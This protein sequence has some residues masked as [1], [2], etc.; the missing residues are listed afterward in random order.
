MGL[1]VGSHSGFGSTN[2]SQVITLLSRAQCLVLTFALSSAWLPLEGDVSY[3][4]WE[5]Q[6][7]LSA[8]ERET[9]RLAGVTQLYWQVGT[10]A[11]DGK[12]WRW[13]E[14]INLDWPAMTA[15]QNHLSIV[16]VLRLA[17]DPGEELP[18][19]TF[20]EVIEK[21]NQLASESGAKQL[22]I[23][24]ECSDLRIPN[25][26]D[27][28][29]RLKE[30]GHTWRLSISA[31]GHWSKYANQFN[32]LA[33]EITPMF[34]DLN[35]MREEMTNGVLPT[36]FDSATA[37]AQILAWKDCSLPW[38]AGL[39]NFSRISV[40]A[41]SGQASGNVR[42]WSWDDIWFS[43][44][45]APSTPT[46]HAQTVFMVTSEGR[47]G[48][49]P[50]SPGETVVVRYP[51]RTALHA[52]LPWIKQAG[53]E[54]AIYFR[55]AGADD[56]SGFSPLDLA[57]EKIVSPSF[58]VSCDES[59]RITIK[60]CSQIDL[61]P[62]VMGNAPGQRGYSLVV[63]ASSAIWRDALP[64][65]FAAVTRQLDVSSE[66]GSAGMTLRFW[67]SHLAAN[68]SLETG[69]VERA[70]G[71]NAARITWRIDNL[72]EENVWHEI[73]NSRQ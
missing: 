43:P 31:L 8:S 29:R 12:S 55:L 56:M 14:K 58:R 72:D 63:H 35:P 30:S 44:F 53:A 64:G 42:K 67:F 2:F 3:W 17:T 19:A 66:S 59:S 60:N 32:G 9:L 45:L 15:D 1:R 49:T 36:L 24:Y 6:K 34:Y 26:L 69:F 71:N 73:D 65:G 18:E 54:G 70:P 16:P 37:Q 28:L 51:E 21:L 39:P 47:L 40:V 46:S 48:W 22:Q 38:R 4:V 25:Y 50:L 5:R 7:P 57:Q 20:P 11:T 61:M 62:Q 13:L 33:D 10:L 52:V 68:N 27:F 23:D 41:K